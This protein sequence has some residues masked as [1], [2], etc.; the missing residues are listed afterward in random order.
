[1]HIPS[2]TL[3]LVVAMTGVTFG[4]TQEAQPILFAATQN[5]DPAKGVY[6]YKLNTTDGS[7]TQWAVTP[8]SFP[9]GGV[10]PTYLQE[11]TNKQ[12]NGKPLIYALNRAT[13]VG[14]VSAMMLNANGKLDLLNTQQMLG[15]S[16]AHITLSPN[17][18]F[19]AVANYA[20]SLSLF[21]LYENGTVAPE[22][23]YEAFP[24]G[25]RVVMDQQATGHIHSTRWLPNSNHVVAFDLGGDTLLQ[26]ELDTTAQTLNK[27]ETVFRPP[28]SGPRHSVLSTD[29]D[30]LYV[31]DEISNTVGVYKINQQKALLESPAVQN[32]TTLPADF[33]STSTAADIHLSKNGKFVY[34][35]NRG[36]N[37][38]AI[39]AIDETNG[40]LTPLGWESTRGRTP[41]GFTIYED[42]L[43]VAN[44]AS[45]DMYV[46]KVDGQ[47]GLLTYTG[48][49]YEIDG[50]VCLLGFIITNREF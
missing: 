37:S 45:D 19:V 6:T 48:N 20:G 32:I 38:V 10:N 7:L 40:T 47:T 22:T 14:Y 16:P 21:P 15:G 12:Y 27:L 42:W 18:D 25:S 49:S 31:T 43:I 34:V 39:Y 30:Y 35:S 8:L 44:Q 11:A 26:Y 9:S 17:E 24:T 36:H 41:R 28:G 2:F 33:T 1:M 13:G 5:S 29:G 23:Y 4:S 50:A 3:F 46:F